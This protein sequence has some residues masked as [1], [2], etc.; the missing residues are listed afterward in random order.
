MC[1][2]FGNR[3]ERN[4]CSNVLPHQAF[5]GRSGRFAGSSATIRGE[6]LQT[7]GA[8]RRN[9]TTR[10][11]FSV[12][13]PKED[14]IQIATFRDMYI[15][16]LQEL[17]S[18]EH[19]LAQSLP[20]MAE[21]AS[22]PELKAALLDHLHE[23]EA[24]KQRIVSILHKHGADPQ[25]HVDQAMQA[26]VH[27]TGKMLRLLDGGELRDAALIASTQKL[28]HYEIAAYGTACALAGQLGLRNDQQTLHD[29]LEEEKAADA[30]LT[31]LA[32]RKINAQA[33]AA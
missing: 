26:L 20:R 17:V 27:E 30:A 7:S 6:A 1:P 19:Q 14:A 16:E 2:A 31:A 8:P 28:E 24:Q 5:L 32:K 23:T 33:A 13:D 15:A 12:E 4:H 29:S 21:V 3:F 18:V 9:K 10:R 22:S 11:C 25:A